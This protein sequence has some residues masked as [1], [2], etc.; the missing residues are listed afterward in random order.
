MLLD[1]A[2]HGL[3]IS[4]WTV[5]VITCIVI[6]INIYRRDGLAA[7][8]LTTLKRRLIIALVVLAIATSLISSGMVFIEP[9]QAGVVVSLMAPQGYRERPLQ[10]GL[11]FIA[12]LLE[13]VQ[14]YPIYWQTYTMSGDP[15]EGARA[16]DD[17]IRA[18]TSDGQEV[19]L[20]C[21]MIFQIASE[22]V[23][24][25]HIDWQ[26]RYIEDY[27]R[28]LVRG[29]IRT[30]VSQYKAEEV[31]SS[32]RADL[33]RE[34][35]RTIRLAL[36]DKGF[37]LDRFILRNV[38]FSEE[39]ASAIERKQVALEEVV[40]SEHQAETM[41]K[42]AKGEADAAR[43][44]AQGEADATL[45]R[46]KAEAEALK[47]IGATLNQDQSLLTY[48]YIEKLAPGVKV[49]LLPNNAPF[50]LPLPAMDQDAT[51]TPSATPNAETPPVASPTPEPTQ[52]TSTVQ[53][54]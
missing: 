31:N 41:R 6:F 35:D 48:R 32:K 2:L 8:L 7:A 26:N 33:E 18:R 27:M 1:R 34:I 30:L 36:E 44:R 16:G 21:S 53:S 10:S 47:L 3:T 14:R 5:V 19:T 13:R 29:E 12:P 25:V 11:R 42:L 39:Y 40:Q 46:A 50:I 23:I 24:R 37:I 54:R 43:L 51:A 22:Q 4:L 38:S 28:P 20:D 45:Q 49:M 15:V 17:S 9:Q 52:P